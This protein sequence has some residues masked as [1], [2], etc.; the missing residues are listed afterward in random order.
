VSWVFPASRT[1]AFS[2]T[3]SHGVHENPIV[4]SC[5]RTYSGQRPGP[6]S[7]PA[8]RLSPVARVIWGSTDGAASPPGKIIGGARSCLCVAHR[9]RRP[10]RRLPTGTGSR[11]HQHSP[12][13][14]PPEERCG[15]QC[16]GW[17]AADS[18]GS[19]LSRA[20]IAVR[21]DLMDLPSTFGVP[22]MDLGDQAPMLARGQIWRSGWCGSRTRGPIARSGRGA[23]S[24]WLA[25]ARVGECECDRPD[26]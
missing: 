22:G 13:L 1:I 3:R 8:H 11:G 7:D 14:S 26:G 5:A 17:P 4:S 25:G 15:S 2:Q 16:P 10:A 6:I 12:R 19:A 21:V 24:W 18:G 20:G 9:I 23:H